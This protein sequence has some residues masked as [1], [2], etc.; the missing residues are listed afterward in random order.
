MWFSII[1]N[2]I[3]LSCGNKFRVFFVKKRLIIDRLERG[4]ETETETERV[5]K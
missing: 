2:Y 3:N 1:C 4:R 5:E